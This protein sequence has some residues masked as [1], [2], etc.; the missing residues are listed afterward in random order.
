MALVTKVIS[1]GELSA[2]QLG[3]LLVATA[4]NPIWSTDSIM[5]L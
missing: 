2:A 3:A 1:E 5:N 4:V